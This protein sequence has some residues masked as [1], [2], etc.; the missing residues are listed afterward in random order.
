MLITLTGP[1]CSGKSTL[2]K[3]LVNNFGWSKIVS[4]T[5]RQMRHGEVDGQDYYFLKECPPDDQLVDKVDFNGNFYG[6]LKSEVSRAETEIKVVVVEPHGVEQLTE[7]CQKNNIPLFKV[8]VG[9]TLEVLIARFLDRYAFDEK[10]NPDY[11]VQRFLSMIEEF[12]TWY[13]PF[14]FDMLITGQDNMEGRI[15]E[16]VDEVVAELEEQ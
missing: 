8:F 3:T 14:L 6:I 12:N 7:Y 2:E 16:V 5:T 10:R 1:T 9:Q 15:K 13:N 4:F 11:Y